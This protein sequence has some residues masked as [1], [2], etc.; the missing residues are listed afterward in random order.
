METERFHLRGQQLSK[1]PSI[2]Q[3]KREATCEAFFFQQE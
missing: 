1:S 2:L 3:Q